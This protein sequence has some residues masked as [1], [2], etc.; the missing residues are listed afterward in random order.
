MDKA[1]GSWSCVVIVSIRPI[2]V[3]C[4]RILPSGVTLL[5]ALFTTLKLY[6]G[7]MLLAHALLYYPW[8]VEI[9]QDNIHEL[10]NGCCSLRCLY[11]GCPGRHRFSYQLGRFSCRDVHR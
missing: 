11:V 10:A 5:I 1:S 2:S 8:F 6:A 7:P 3:L 9:R 4:Q